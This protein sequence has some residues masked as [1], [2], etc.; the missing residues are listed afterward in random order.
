MQVG[1]RAASHFVR[2]SALKARVSPHKLWVEIDSV[3]EE[4]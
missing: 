4:Y 2:G 3:R 1:L